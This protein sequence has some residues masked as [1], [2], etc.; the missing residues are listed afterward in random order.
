MLFGV[1]G[2]AP[3]ITR[4]SDLLPILRNSLGFL[5]GAVGAYLIAQATVGRRLQSIGGLTP[6]RIKTWWRR[7]HRSR[8]RRLSSIP[9]TTHHVSDPE[10]DAAPRD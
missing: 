6:H 3:V 9:G 4:T 1:F 7:R 8:H 10:V 2:I 5:G